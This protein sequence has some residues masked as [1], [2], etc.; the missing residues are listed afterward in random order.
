MLYLVRRLHLVCGEVRR[1]Q[2]VEVVDGVVRGFSPF[3]VERQSMLWVEEGF[4]SHSSCACVVGDFIS[5]VPVDSG[6]G[7]LF[8]YICDCDDGQALASSLPVTRV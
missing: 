1:M 5:V 2:V 6:A 7:P 4:L 3:D 8:F